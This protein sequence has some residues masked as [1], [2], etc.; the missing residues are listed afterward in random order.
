MRNQTWQKNEVE[1]NCCLTSKL[2]RFQEL[3]TVKPKNRPGL[4]RSRKNYPT[5]YFDQ[6]SL[7]S[8]GI[9]LGPDS[10]KFLSQT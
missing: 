1:Y 6:F 3:M 9:S 4:V 7:Y 5:Y 10:Q 8:T 2:F